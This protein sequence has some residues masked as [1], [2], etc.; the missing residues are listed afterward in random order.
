MSATQ[1]TADH[2]AA[3]AAEHPVSD[4]LE[5]LREHLRHDIHHFAHMLSEQGPMNITFVHNNT[6]LGLQSKHFD[7]AIREARR[8]LGARGYEPLES[9]RG[10]HRRGRIA[11]HQLERALAD[12]ALPGLDDVVVPRASGPLTMC[13]V[14]RQ[15][16]LHDLMPIPPEELMRRARDEEA[17]V[18]PPQHLSDAA[19]QAHGESTVTALVDAATQ[20]GRD[21]LFSDW[22]APLVGLDLRGELRRLACEQAETAASPDDVSVAL[23]AMG[24]PGALHERYLTL[25]SA[26]T[27]GGVTSEPELGQALQRAVVVAE[28]SLVDELCRRHWGFPGRI[29]DVIAALRLQPE[30]FATGALWHAVLGQLDLDDPL[31]PTDPR[32]L[33]P[34]EPLLDL[35]EFID[36]LAETVGDGPL[37]LRVDRPMRRA[38]RALALDGGVHHDAAGLRALDL[39][40]DALESGFLSAEASA[41]VTALLVGRDDESA[42]RL[43]AQLAAGDG[44]VRQIASTRAL[45]AMDIEALG[46]G[47]THADW[48]LRLTGEDLIARINP[49]MIRWC[50]AFIDEGLTA[51]R[52]PGRYEGFFASWRVAVVS[53][54]SLDLEGLDDWRVDLERLPARAEDAIMAMLG[55]LGVE[56]AAWGEYLGR[57][58]SQL[59]GWAGMAYWYELHPKHYKQSQQSIDSIQYVA[60]RLFYEYQY[61]RAACRRHFGVEE[62]IDQL[63]AH[64]E[65]RLQEYRLRLSL[66]AC[67]LSDSL[68]EPAR[69]L[70]ADA[71]TTLRAAPRLRH[72]ADAAWLEGEA[73]TTRDQAASEAWP[74]YQ[75]CLHLGINAVELRAMAAGEVQLLQ[76]ALQRCTEDRMSPI[77]LDAYERHYR[78]EVLNALA[79]NPGRG[80][81]AKGRSRR[82]KSQVVFC[83]DEREE[84]LHRHYGELD[85]EHETLG[86]AGFFG[87]AQSFT[88]LDD[89]DPT[90]L[91]PAVATPAHR[92]LEIPRLE[93]LH[94][95]FPQHKRRHGWMGVAHDSYWETKRN[96]FGSFFLIQLA[97]LFMSV[98]LLGRVFAPRTFSHLSHQVH[99]ALVPT[100]RT[101]LTHVRMNEDQLRRWGLHSGALPIGMQINEAADRVEAQLRNW[102]LTYQFARIV[103]I[104]AHRSFSVNNPHENAHDCGA[105][106]GKAGGPNSRLFSALANDPQVRTELRQR[107]LD[108]P[109]DTWFV[110]AEHNTCN[111]AILAFDTED[112]PVSLQADWQLV[113]ADLDEARKRGARERCRRFGS[114]PKDASPE[115]SLAHVEARSEDIS[116]V[117]PEW[118]HCTNAFAVVGRRCLTQG[119]FF[120]RRGFIISYDPTQDPDGKIL[121]RILLAVGPVGAGINLEYY[122]S[123]VD[124]DNYGC[125]TKVPHNVVGMVGVMAGAHGDLQTGLPRQM[126]EVHEAMRL[127]LVVDAP[128]AVLGAIYGRQPGIQQLLDNQWVH[129]IASDPETGELNMF[130]PGVGFVAWKEPLTPLPEVS[131]SY[132]WFKGKYECFLPPARIAEPTRRWNDRGGVH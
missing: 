42:G 86:A 64:F 115:A 14:L 56:P 7:A 111:D 53:D 96:L 41:A 103:V 83:I 5:A 121:E 69:E 81:W 19:R 33:L 2:H 20:I 68:A 105:C 112:I 91:C 8:V 113:R 110:G 45:L 102:G 38:L 95:E 80:R 22:L 15:A 49:Q 11:I 93:A 118:G 16:L 87:V 74:L 52:M 29:D 125:G 50:G 58:L 28:A 46:Q 124:P 61:V 100:V 101:R 18:S 129:L 90:P 32:T 75:L 98:P 3:D 128:M 35:G 84:N 44:R 25:C 72:L 71:R 117:R 23:N 17:L 104:C 36:S 54:R 123:T 88:A 40:N 26:L 47:R 73:L 13:D 27:V 108:I 82:P 89:H 43:R 55:R 131:D 92:I 126:T 21:G 31:S 4:D 12:S 78:D 127:Q 62:R 130:K 30:R 109:D 57:M 63:R 97:G 37:P 6:L 24:V 79:Q 66:H 94:E 65:S 34:F 59:K 77:W 10:H 106:G 107:G 119:L 60:V 132:E 67:K 9:F 114:A 120:D 85:P 39:V 99:D 116:Q 70:L 122:F 51:W 48:I 1:H 76:D